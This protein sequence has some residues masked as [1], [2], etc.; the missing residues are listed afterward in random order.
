MDWLTNV[1]QMQFQLRHEE[2]MLEQAGIQSP[3]T[4]G[5][6]QRLCVAPV[7]QQDVDAWLQEY[8]QLL[9]L[10][11]TASK[12]LDEDCKKYC[13]KYTQL[14]LQRGGAPPQSHDVATKLNMVKEKFSNARANLKRKC[15]EEVEK[16]CG[17]RRGKLPR[18]ATDCLM[19]W[20]SD[21]VQN[22]YPTDV[23]KQQ[24]LEESGLTLRQL[25]DWF[26]NTRRRT[27]APIMGLA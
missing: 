2:E 24:L 8:I 7:L 19:R 1:E 11:L 9:Q 3:T 15:N 14:L 12:K 10:Y 27:W 13:E 5:H 20:F 16:L 22:P 6:H 17:G 23:E 21:H 18:T 26:I 25:N 4:H